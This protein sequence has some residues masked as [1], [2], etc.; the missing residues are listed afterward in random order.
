MNKKEACEQKFEAQ[1]DE[2]NAE[3]DSGTLRNPRHG[4]QWWICR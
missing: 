4:P 1:L 3:I 2:L